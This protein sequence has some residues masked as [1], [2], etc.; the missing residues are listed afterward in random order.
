MGG[1]NQQASLNHNAG[2]SNKAKHTGKPPAYLKPNSQSMQ[3]TYRGEVTIDCF[4]SQ[5]HV[6]NQPNLLFIV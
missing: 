5:K 1:E 3:K 6:E 4:R 2:Y